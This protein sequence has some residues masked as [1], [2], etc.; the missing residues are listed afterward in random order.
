MSNAH[1]S[2]LWIVAFSGA[3]VFACATAQAFD[4]EVAAPNSGNC[5]VAV[6]PDGWYHASAQF[7]ATNAKQRVSV[8]LRY[9]DADGNSCGEEVALATSGRSADKPFRLHKVVR[10]PSRAARCEMIPQGG[11][12]LVRNMRL[13]GSMDDCRDET[14]GTQLLNGSFEEA[15]LNADFVDC[16]CIAHGR[17][18]RTAE[19]ADH[20]LYALR[21]TAGAALSY[22]APGTAAVAVRAGE[23]LNGHLA[24]RGGD[25]DVQFSFRDEGGRRCGAA[26][27]RLDGGPAWRGHDFRLVPPQGAVAATLR[28]AADSDADIDSAYLGRARYS[29]ERMP[30]P[31]PAIAHVPRVPLVLPKSEVK[32]FQG[33]PT[34]F[35]DGKPIVNSLYTCRP[36]PGSDPKSLAYHHEIIKKGNFPIYVVGNKITCDDAAPSN[37][38]G[39]HNPADF[40]KLV[41]F[42]I[43]FILKA[44]PDAL[45][46]VWFQQYP[47][48]T[49]ADA[50]PDECARVEDGDQGFRYDIPGYS[51]G[52]ETWSRYCEASVESFLAGILSRPYGSQIVGFMPGFGNFG[53][54]N[55]GHLDGTRYLSPHDFSPAM[56][57]FFRKWLLQEYGG[58]VMAFAAAWG[59]KGFSFAHAQAPTMLQRVPRLGGGFLDPVRQ[60]NVIDYARCESFAILHRVDRQCRAAKEFTGGR[61][62]T[63]SEIGYLS[64]R[65]NHREMMPILNSKWLDSFGPAPGYM[66]RGPGDDIPVNAPVASLMYHNKVFL[67]QSDVRSHRF[68]PEKHRFGETLTADESVAVYRRELGKYMTTGIVPY[69]WTFKRWWDDPKI[70]AEV[71]KYDRWMRLSARFPRRSLAQVAVVLDPLSLSAGIEYNYNRQPITVAQ[72]VS[73]NRNLEW[74]RLGAPY[75]LWLLDDLIESGELDRYKVVVFPAQVALTVGQRRAIREKMGRNG[76]TL[77]WIYAPGAF[78]ADG[79]HLSLSSDNT[80]VC[81]FTLKKETA[82]HTLVMKA[83]KVAFM[84]AFG[85]DAVEDRLGCSHT[86]LYGGFSYKIDYVNPKPIP[87]EVFEARFLVKDEPGVT[88]LARYEEGGA[89]AA[90]VRR[91]PTYTSVFWGAGILNVKAFRAIAAAAGVHLY[92]DRPA[93]LYANMNFGVVHLKDAGPIRITLPRKASKTIDLADGRILAEDSDSFMVDPGANGTCLFHFQ[94]GEMRASN[95]DETAQKCR[96]KK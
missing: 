30:P 36:R 46:L 24:V 55:Y 84:S 26:H 43:R 54:N 72:H 32:P 78:L 92:T 90:A 15:D 65:Y 53:E 86:P 68:T 25:V 60:R 35:V 11:A 94:A 77:V 10:V 12:G 71:P 9:V 70:M 44:K 58:D 79:T 13:D 18:K 50:Y 7:L 61:I 1:T 37:P 16:W 82:L 41:D 17:A 56:A 3:V 31:A 38:M 6:T 87:P 67:F 27:M 64:Q 48:R 69:Q 29:V 81:G 5:G 45:F 80:D 2:L 66:N 75:D 22:A 28:I 95:G 8:K 96:Q 76:R 40:L 47:S 85:S 88:V 21:L 4:I 52:S 34:W 23:A 62:F 51:Y 19:G 14:D 93:V 63:C 89:P 83:D 42:Q 39:P 59:R 49:F 20:G 57:N 33:V 91:F 74:H 73:F